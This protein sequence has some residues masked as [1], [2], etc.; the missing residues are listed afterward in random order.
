VQVQRGHNSTNLT[1]VTIQ[2]GIDHIGDNTFYGCTGLTVITIPNS[3]KTIGEGVF[4]IDSDENTNLTSITIGSNVTLTEP[5]YRD[6]SFG[7]RF[8]R[9]YNRGGKKA[10]TY[11]RLNTKSETWTKQ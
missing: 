8:E 6:G 9:A 4:C 11:T 7:A 1:S 2:N 5:S 3:V 10:G